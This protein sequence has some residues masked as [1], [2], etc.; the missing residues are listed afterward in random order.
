[1]AQ[2]PR[3]QQAPFDRGGLTE[4]EDS[5]SESPS[6]IRENLRGTEFPA[7]REELR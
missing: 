7:S 3:D 5:A 6:E 1:M 4:N 2:A